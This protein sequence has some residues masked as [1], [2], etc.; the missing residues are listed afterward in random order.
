MT[1]ISAT[2]R[3]A[4]AGHG[5][6][7][8]VPRRAVLALAL[9]LSAIATGTIA[10]PAMTGAARAATPERLKP[11]AVGEMS[12]FIVHEAAKPV[13]A[14]TF[15]EKSGRELDLSAFRGKVVL[16]NLWATWCVPCRAEMPALDRLQQRLAGRPFTVVAVAQERGGYDKAQAFLDEIGT[17]SLT[18]YIDQS[19]KSARAW[20][21]VGL[22][23][24]M[25]LD[26]EGRE[27]GRLLGEAKWDSEQAVR[28]IETL[29]PRP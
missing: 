23:T 7:P 29:L 22:P 20:G 8:D 15:T 16:V 6:V 12:K 14:A 25:L 21:A 13:A 28:L 4:P 5:R 11:L 1:D 24:T 17:R 3:T 18:L 26:P 27:V 10:V 19:M 2:T 9:A